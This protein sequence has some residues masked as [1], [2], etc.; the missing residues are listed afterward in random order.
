MEAAGVADEQPAEVVE[1]GAMPAAFQHA[2]AELL[3]K[4]RDGAR[5]RRLRDALRRRGARERAVLGD[6]QQDAQMPRVDI[7]NSDLW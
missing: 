5:H 3:F 1:I 7:H 2:H 4:P 6:R